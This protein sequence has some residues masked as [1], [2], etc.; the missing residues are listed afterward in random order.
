[1]TTS[2]LSIV[3]GANQGAAR[4]A[5]PALDVNA[6]AIADD[7]DLTLL[8]KGFGVELAVR[9]AVTHPVAVAGVAVPSAE[10]LTD[11]TGLIASGVRVLASASDLASRGLAPNDLLDGIDA[12]DD[13]AIA[14]L[15]LTHDVTLSCA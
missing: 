3:R 4:T 9:N 11:L 7:I 12:V 8:L 15:L 13:A 6:Y 1:M 10:P 5:V 14:G 2:V